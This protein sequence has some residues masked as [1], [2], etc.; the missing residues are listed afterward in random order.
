L[1]ARSFCTQNDI[2]IAD[3]GGFPRGN[4]KI[5]PIFGGRSVTA[6]T[7]KRTDKLK[8]AI[9]TFRG[10]LHKLCDTLFP[11]PIGARNPA[12]PSFPIFT[13]EE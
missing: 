7:N 9:Y 3:H 10:I 4:P 2:G 8:F 5:V 13:K 11:K 6:P 12:P 1:I